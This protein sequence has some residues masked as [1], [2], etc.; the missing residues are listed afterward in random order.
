MRSPCWEQRVAE[1]EKN[2]SAMQIV[3]QATV[4]TMR[5]EFTESCNNVVDQASFKFANIELQARELHE[6]TEAIV[7]G[8]EQEFHNIKSTIAMTMQDVESAVA[9]ISQRVSALEAHAGPC[10][11]SDTNQ[12]DRREAQNNGEEQYRKAAAQRHR[13]E[14]RRGD[15]CPRKTRSQGH[16]RENWTSGAQGGTM[17]Q[18]S[19]TRATPECS[20]SCRESV[21][22]VAEQ[23]AQVVAEFVRVL[24]EQI[25]VKTKMKLSPEDTILWMVRSARS[26]AVLHVRDDEGDDAEWEANEFL[27][28]TP[29]GVVRAFSYRRRSEGS[30]WD[31]DLIK[32]MQGTPQ[33]PDPTR[34]GVGIPI[35]VR[36]S[37]PAHVDE[38]IPKQ[39]ARQ[40]QG[41]RRMRIMLEKYGFTF[42]M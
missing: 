8:A 32:N 10:D 13:V 25:E 18:T 16:S 36:F 35:K 9:T 42:G 11:F 29:S 4:Q 14:R 24:G 6:N 7:D 17:L 26:T 12:G 15:I 34:P 31:A 2:A 21:E 41:P 3:N 5:K 20:N 22:R 23:A 27:I 1:I 33:Q 19:W 30:R 38:A 39:L 28:G 37:E 40:E